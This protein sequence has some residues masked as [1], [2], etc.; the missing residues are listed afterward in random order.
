MKHLISSIS[1]FE[2]LQRG[3]IPYSD[4]AGHIRDMEIE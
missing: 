2:E 4:A 1:C 3:K